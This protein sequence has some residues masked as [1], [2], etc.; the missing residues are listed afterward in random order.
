MDS[1]PFPREATPVTSTLAHAIKQSIIG[2][3][4]AGF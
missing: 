2:N 1:G 4:E 3:Y